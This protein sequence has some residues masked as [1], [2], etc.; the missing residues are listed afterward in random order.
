MAT[1]LI[2]FLFGYVIGYGV[3]LLLNRW[4]D[5]IKNGRR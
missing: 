2:I 4:D 1:S 5:E 3:G